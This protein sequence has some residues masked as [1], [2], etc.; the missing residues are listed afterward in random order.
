MSDRHSQLKPPGL[1]VRKPFLKPLIFG[2]GSLL[3]VVAL[4]ALLILGM[5]PQ[6][7]SP[8]GEINNLSELVSA[9]LET[10]GGRENIEAVVSIRAHGKL[11]DSASEE[12]LQF[13]IVKRRPHFYRAVFQSQRATVTEYFDGDQAWRLVADHRSGQRQLTPLTGSEREHII[14]QAEFDSLIFRESRNLDRLRF[15]GIRDYLGKNFYEIRIVTGDINHERSILIDPQT[16]Q[17]EIHLDY[18]VA[19]GSTFT[20][21]QD[22][23]REVRGLLIPH[24]ITRKTDGTEQWQMS[25]ERIDLNIGITKSLFSPE[26][27]P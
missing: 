12:P 19:E 3:L 15:M 17:D 16:L 22:Q 11:F 8:S 5:R 13:T 1:F 27:Q 23:F 4:T 20:I 6:P 18:Q 2:A 9:Y 25:F 21:H 14:Q 24:R 7:A 26:I 10:H